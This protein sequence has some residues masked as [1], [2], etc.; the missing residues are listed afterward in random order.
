MDL[1]RKPG[2]QRKKLLRLPV[3]FQAAE[4]SQRLR[5]SAHARTHIHK[6]THTSKWGSAGGS[7]RAV[8]V[9]MC[10]HACVGEG[11]ESEREHESVYVDGRAASGGSGGKGDQYF[12]NKCLLLSARP[13]DFVP[14]LVFTIA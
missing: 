14:F 9:D 6:Y 2:G 13:R 4:R 3:A 7:S 11:C 10:L 1:T 5:L 8:C 12:D